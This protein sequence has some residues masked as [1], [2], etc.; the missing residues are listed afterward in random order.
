MNNYRY[1]INH[2]REERNNY[3]VKPKQK[4]GRKEEVRYSF[5]VADCSFD[6]MQIV[7]KANNASRQFPTTFNTLPTHAGFPYPLLRHCKRIYDPNVGRVYLAG[8]C[9]GHEDRSRHRACPNASFLRNVS[10]FGLLLYALFVP[11]CRVN[12]IRN[13]Q[14]TPLVVN[15]SHVTPRDFDFATIHRFQFPPTDPLP[16]LRSYK[17]KLEHIY[18]SWMLGNRDRSNRSFV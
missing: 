15:S 17:Q 6:V 8:L 1:Y 3:K 13:S 10:S 11:Y 2:P 7:F 4:N 14:K 16:Q 12:M 9:R 18:N 5:R